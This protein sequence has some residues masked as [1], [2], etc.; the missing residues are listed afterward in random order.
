MSVSPQHWTRSAAHFHAV[1]PSV[2]GE[3]SEILEMRE[4]F[5][6]TS[7]HGDATSNTVLG[8]ATF[9]NAASLW[10]RLESANTGND[11]PGATQIRGHFVL[12]STRAH[13]ARVLTDCGGSTSI[14][15]A[16]KKNGGFVIG[17]NVDQVASAV[18]APIDIASAYDF[19]LNGT[20]CHPHTLFQGVNVCDPASLT[21][22]EEKNSEPVISSYWHPS[23]SETLS[24]RDA[25]EAVSAALQQA[26]VDGQANEPAVNI[27]FSG[28]EDSRIV[29]SLVEGEKA[30]YI[31]LPYENREL[32]LARIAAKFLGFPLHHVPMRPDHYSGSIPEKIRILG[33]G[34]DTCHFHSYGLDIFLSRNRT[35]GGWGSDTFL[36]GHYFKKH[37]AGEPI[38]G[39]YSTWRTDAP[40]PFKSEIV[41][42]RQSWNDRL[43]AH[44]PTTACDWDRYWPLSAHE[45]YSTF[46][47]SR[48]IYDMRE[49]FLTMELVQLSAHILPTDKTSFAVMR[50]LARKHLGIS[51]FLPRS[52]GRIPRLSPAVNA[53]ANRALVR[54]AFQFHQRYVHKNRKQGPWIIQS[55]GIPPASEVAK[56]LSELDGGRMST[57]LNSIIDRK[58]NASRQKRFIL[59]AQQI[60]VIASARDADLLR[61]RHAH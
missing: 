35:F 53:L 37:L 28:G 51:G 18:Y 4:I 5:F 52:D 6:D 13:C 15:W 33:S 59:R 61:H 49:P 12:L 44:L 39:R 1:R 9:S 27:F 60:S 25:I 42:R 24:R 57:W 22:F 11:I 21:V 50:G 32:V 23:E 55:E 36:K 10:T 29:A 43:A 47:G 58:D 7:Q 40:E 3:V 31:F 45:H 46:A 56:Q 30:G 54:P 20:V 17:T 19:L 34:F 41:A 16:R 48:R 26:V 14:F 8:N 2:G 38:L